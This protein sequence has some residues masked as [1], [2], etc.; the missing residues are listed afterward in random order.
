M[1]NSQFKKVVL[2]NKCGILDLVGHDNDISF[3]YPIALSH[4]RDH[5][6]HLV[7]VGEEIPHRIDFT[8]N[9]WIRP[10]HKETVSKQL[11]DIANKYSGLD[12]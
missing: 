12:D 11:C 3:L 6:D 5:P 8:M 4:K 2:C 7:V 1:I 9:I 10:E